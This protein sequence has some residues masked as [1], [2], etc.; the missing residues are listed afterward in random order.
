MLIADCSTKTLEDAGDPMKCCEKTH[1]RWLCSA[2]NPGRGL[3]EGWGTSGAPFSWEHWESMSPLH[4]FALVFFSCPP[5]WGG[6]T[7]RQQKLAKIYCF[8]KPSQNHQPEGKA[9]F[10]NLGKVI[11]C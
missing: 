7:N 4:H 11:S 8:L 10:G 3:K 1:L 9:E 6:G 2:A 5:G